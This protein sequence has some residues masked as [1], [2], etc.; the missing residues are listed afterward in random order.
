LKQELANR[1]I[2]VGRDTLEKLLILWGFSLARKIR[3]KKP[4]IIEKILLALGERANLL[5]RSAITE[6]LQA[7]TSDIT[8]LWYANGSKRAYLAEHKDAFGQIIYGW[9]VSERMDAVL[10]RSSFKRACKSIRQITLR[11]PRLLWHQDR[12]SQ[13]TSY[14]YVEDVLRVGVLS[15]SRKGRPTDN[16][17]QESCFGRFKDEWKEEIGDL[18]SFRDVVRFIEKNL[19]YYNHKRLHTSISNQTPYAFTRAHLALREPATPVF[20]ILPQWFRFSRT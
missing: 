16:S 9:A 10:V 20:K 6:P 15:Y 19:R 3:R 5:K 18:Q 11:L 2:I 7:I 1:N 8:V 4:S 17:G 13:Y 14:E 12:G